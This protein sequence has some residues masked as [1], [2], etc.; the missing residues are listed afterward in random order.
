[1]KEQSGKARNGYRGV[2]N[3]E[4]HFTNDNFIEKSKV[5]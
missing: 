2:I 1:M 4:K 5:K 3:L